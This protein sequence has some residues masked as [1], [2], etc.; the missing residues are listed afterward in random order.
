MKWSYLLDP[1]GHTPEMAG[2]FL[3][4]RS[5]IIWHCFFKTAASN[6]PYPVGVFV[7]SL[8][9]SSESLGHQLNA[10]LNLKDISGLGVQF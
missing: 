3:W 8:A 7:F 6:T 9:G 1:K 2:I 4:T 5:V 10:K